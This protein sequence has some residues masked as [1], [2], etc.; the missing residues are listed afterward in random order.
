[1][2]QVSLGR[3]EF[4]PGTSPR[5]PDRQIPLCDFSLSV[6][7]SPYF[8]PILPLLLH[9]CPSP[10][11][12]GLRC[13]QYR[14]SF[15][16]TRS[17]LE[18]S[19]SLEMFNLDLQ[20]STKKRGFWWVATSSSIF[21]NE[22]MQNSVTLCRIVSR[23]LCFSLGIGRGGCVRNIGHKHAF[24]RAQKAENTDPRTNYAG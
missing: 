13:W 22:I 17:W 3:P 9:L 16:C 23:F 11:R 21:S 20:N 19:I 14:L 6:F 1:M 24:C 18:T 4:V 15:V 5:H 12:L 2:S 7:F 8:S 10:W